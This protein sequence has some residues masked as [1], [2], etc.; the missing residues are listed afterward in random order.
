MRVSENSNYEAIRSSIHRSKERMENLQFQSA[1][2]RRINTPSDDPVAAAK[3]LELRTDKMNNDQYQ[4]N[5]KMAETFLSNT[6]SAIADLSEIVVRAKELAIA[7][8]STSTSSE[9]TRLAISEEITQLYNQAIG[10]ANRRVG[11]RYLFGGYKTQKPPVDPE[12]KYHGDQGQVMVE[13]SKDVFLSMNVPGI[14]VFNTHP[15]SFMARQAAMTEG[16]G[17]RDSEGDA[18]GEV[19]VENVNLFDE[20]QRF[21]IGLLTGNLHLVHATLERF[22]EMH[23]TLVTTQ[24][25]IGSRLQGLQAAGR[26]IERQNITNASLSSGLEDSDMAQVMSDLSKEES[27]FRNSLASSKRLIQPTLLDFL[28]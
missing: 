27:I 1:T 8:S 26:T 18:R 9:S 7:Q 11:E 5:A 22:D 21:R 6:E 12:G 3:I 25:K 4:M 13:I 20:L 28:K 19:D 10:I 16:Y 23:S 17:A 24:A 2:L 15:K 14:D